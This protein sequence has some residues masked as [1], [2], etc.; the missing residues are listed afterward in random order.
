MPDVMVDRRASPRY[1]L[2][3]VAEVTEMTSRSKFSARSS[4]VSRTGCYIDTLNPVPAGTNVIVRLLRGTE[5]FEAVGIV[6]YISPGPG[7]GVHFDE[8]IPVHQLALLDRWLEE[9]AKSNH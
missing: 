2:V 5:N 7:M 1:P 9:A 8:H 3:L 4:D 6:K